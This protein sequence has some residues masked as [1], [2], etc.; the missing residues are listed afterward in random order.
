[1]NIDENHLIQKVSVDQKDKCVII[2]AGTGL[3]IVMVKDFLNTNSSFQVF[4]SECGHL[5]VSINSL[6]DYEF[7]RFVKE[8]MKLKPSSYVSIE[9]Y[10]AGLGLVWMYK[11]LC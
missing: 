6:E 5:P 7:E 8:N 1:M 9:Y 4:A 11:Y 10:I 2:G 3:G